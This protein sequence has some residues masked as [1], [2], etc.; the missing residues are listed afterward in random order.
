MASTIIMPPLLFHV[1]T[2]FKAYT[3]KSQNRECAEL[4]GLTEEIK[5]KIFTPLFTTK[6]KGQ[7][8]A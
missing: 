7:G 1:S 6:S 8:L 3:K 2:K 5:P 4:T